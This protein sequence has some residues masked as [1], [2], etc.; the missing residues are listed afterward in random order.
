MTGEKLAGPNFERLKRV[1][2]T[3]KGSAARTKKAGWWRYVE[4][5]L[6]FLDDFAQQAGGV[7]PFWQSKAE[8]QVVTVGGDRGLCKRDP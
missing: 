8:Q 7:T 6:L 3:G 5:G 1:I 2:Y 4:Q